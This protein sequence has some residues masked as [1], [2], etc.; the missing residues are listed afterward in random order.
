MEL[1][2]FQYLQEERRKIFRLQTLLAKK[3]KSSEEIKEQNVLVDEKCKAEEMMDDPEYKVLM[4]D[5]GESLAYF[6]I[7]DVDFMMGS[8][9]G[10]TI[11]KI[12]DKYSDEEYKDKR[13]RFTTRF[14]LQGRDVI[15][16]QIKE[17]RKSTAG[18]AQPESNK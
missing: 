1:S 2:I 7:E 12:S 14:Y 18:V 10:S 15:I 4:K 9:Y 5:I 13:I 16:K 11:H 6:S 3:D 17:Y 8:I